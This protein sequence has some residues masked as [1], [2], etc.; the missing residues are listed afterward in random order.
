MLCQI[1]QCHR[2]VRSEKCGLC[3]SHYRKKLRYGDPLAK[4][5]GGPYQ[6]QAC[7]VG[8][9]WR[10]VTARGWCHAHWERERTTGDVQADV[11]LKTQGRRGFGT[12]DGRGYRIV[13]HNG[14]RMGLHRVVMEFRLGRELLPDEEVHHKNGVR[15]DNR[16]ENLELWSKSHPAGQRIEDLLDWAQM[17]Q[18]RY[19]ETAT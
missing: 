12:I 11:P 13:Y 9:C 15:D 16:Y 19:Q 6:G 10:P 4:R 18:E 2:Q 14:K 17:I 8:G 7:A 1:N 5:Y 3:D